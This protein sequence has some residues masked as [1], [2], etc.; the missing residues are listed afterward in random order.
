MSNYTEADVKKWRESLVV[1]LGDAAKSPTPAA[2]LKGLEAA[3]LEGAKVPG[4][5]A[6]NAALVAALRSALQRMSAQD[7]HAARETLLESIE[8]SHPGT[9]LLAEHEAKVSTLKARVAERDDWRRKALDRDLQVVGLTSEVS[10]LQSQVAELEHA[11]E[12][13]GRF[14]AE[15][16]RARAEGLALLS[17]RDALRAQVA[18]F[19]QSATTAL[20]MLA[21]GQHALVEANLRLAISAPPA[22]TTPQVASAFTPEQVAGLQALGVPVE[23]AETTLAPERQEKW[24]S[25]CDSVHAP[26]QNASCWK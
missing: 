23:P 9:D 15:R 7:W 4:L 11:K 21:E 17:E 1:G 25:Q 18:Q 12:E 26:G 5:V 14:L 6:D 2:C 19:K 20:V 13:A 24:C 16:D 10:A 3:A 22:E 8:K